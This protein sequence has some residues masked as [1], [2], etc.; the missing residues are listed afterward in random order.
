AAFLV[1]IW[2][3]RS[4]NFTHTRHVGPMIL[5]A[6][7]A[8]AF[9]AVGV[10]GWSGL[11]VGPA[12]ALGAGAAALVALCFGAGALPALPEVSGARVRRILDA[13][14]LPLA[15]AFIPV[16]FFA[17]GVYNLVWP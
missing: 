1:V 16:V 17:Q 2:L 3:L 4:R 15:I 6:A 8:T 12:A 13:L 5:A 9:L 14:D 11:A 10:A 7:A